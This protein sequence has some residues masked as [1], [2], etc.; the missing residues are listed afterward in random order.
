MNLR[1]AAFLVA[2]SFTIAAAAAD[3]KELIEQAH[4]QLQ[5]ARSTSSEEGY[6]KAEETVD[7]A[8]QQD[9]KNPLAL[10]MR[11][12]IRMERAG[13]LASKGRF[14]PANETMTVACADLDAAVAMSPGTL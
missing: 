10:M 2:M 12:A 13:W 14:V 9:P 7:K 5:A 8:V 1:H 6:L 11:G 4:T 3:T